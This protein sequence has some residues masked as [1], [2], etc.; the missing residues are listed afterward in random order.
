MKISGRKLIFMQVMVH[1]PTSLLL[2]LG[3]FN[4]TDPLAFYPAC[5]SGNLELHHGLNLQ[6]IDYSTAFHESC[7][8]N[9]IDIAQWLYYEAGQGVID[10]FVLAD[11]NKDFI[12]CKKFGYVKLVEWLYS[13]GG[14]ETRIEPNDYKFAFAKDILREMVISHHSFFALL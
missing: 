9:R 8:S 12:Y 13:L 10:I 4:T 11:A 2:Q 5:Q 3:G 7:T 1:I 6:Q 14:F